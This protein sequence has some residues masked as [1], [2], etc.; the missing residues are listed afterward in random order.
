MAP[1]LAI[2]GVVDK[3]SPIAHRSVVRLVI[4]KVQASKKR[5]C[6]LRK[7]T[8]PFSTQVFV[9]YSEV[10]W[11][12][13]KLLCFWE[14][15]T[16]PYCF[17]KWLMK[18]KTNFSN[19]SNTVLIVYRNAITSRLLQYVDEKNQTEFSKCNCHNIVEISSFCLKHY[20]LS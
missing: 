6:R 20:C 9:L 17:S 14:V 5:N 10:K 16:R 4:L 8:I 18:P 3:K 11:C 1:L 15:Q 19:F 13:P 2:V 7:K 12:K